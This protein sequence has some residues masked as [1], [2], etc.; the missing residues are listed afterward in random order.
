MQ[1]DIGFQEKPVEG[2]STWFGASL[3][4]RISLNQKTDFSQRIEIYSD[5][6][7]VI[8]LA[9]R[10]DGFDMK[11]FS[12][13]IDRKLQSGVVWRSEIR[14]FQSSNPIIPAQSTD[15]EDNN[16]LF[17]TSLSYRF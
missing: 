6:D 15:F 10:P 14:H 7:Q 3:I 16:Q 4:S 2:E 9:N 11:S 5:Q 12:L 13:G 17:V 1:A 8:V